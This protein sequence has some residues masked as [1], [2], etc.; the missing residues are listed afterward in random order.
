MDVSGEILAEVPVLE[1][2]SIPSNDRTV[3]VKV[4]ASAAIA[5][6]IAGLRVQQSWIGDALPEVAQPLLDSDI[7]CR[8]ERVTA[9]EIRA[10]IKDGCRDLNEVK[11]LTRAG[12]GACGGKTCQTLIMRLFRECGIPMD[13]VTGGVPRPLFVEVPLGVLAGTVLDVSEQNQV[14]PSRLSS[15]GAKGG[16]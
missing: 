8:C 13:D 7:V 11:T 10:V 12:M 14:P 6:R 16:E 5:E 3:L 1:V 15:L 4:Q 9:G 2:R